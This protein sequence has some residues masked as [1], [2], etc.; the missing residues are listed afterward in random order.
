MKLSK[1]IQKCQQILK[2][3][4]DISEFYTLDYKS[5]MHA[6]G[7]YAPEVRYLSDDEPVSRSGRVKNL[8]PII[9]DDESLEDWIEENNIDIEVKDGRIDW[10]EFN[11]SHTK[12]IVL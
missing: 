3:H 9:E 5:G 11:K 6:P 4:G 2:E 7:G 10:D 1:Y 8:I 12:V